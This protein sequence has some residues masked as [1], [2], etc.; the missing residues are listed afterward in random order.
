MSVCVHVCV[1]AHACVCARMHVCVRACACG[2]VCVG[3]CV[4]SVLVTEHTSIQL[5][6]QIVSEVVCVCIYI[7]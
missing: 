2:W 4:R 5:I 7:I 1:C 6:S 3:V